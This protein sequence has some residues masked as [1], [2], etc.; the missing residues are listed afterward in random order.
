MRHEEWAVRGG[1]RAARVSV[2]V[3]EWDAC[4]G[5]EVTGKRRGMGGGGRR[6]LLS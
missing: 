3:R 6:E 4:H 1:Q 5:N 2:G